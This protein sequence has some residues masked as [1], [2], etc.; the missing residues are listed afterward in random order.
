MLMSLFSIILTNVTMNIIC[1]SVSAMTDNE[2]G[3]HSR[4]FLSTDPYGNP[5]CKQCS[6]CPP[7]TGVRRLCEGTSDTECEICPVGMYSGTWSSTRV[8]Q[9]CQVC[10]PHRQITRN[11]TSQHNSKC[12][13]SCDF[14]FYLNALTDFCDECS[15]CFPDQP[16]H[17]PPRITECIQQGVAREFQCMPTMGNNRHYSLLRSGGAGADADEASTS[18]DQQGVENE[19][20]VGNISDGKANTTITTE[21]DT[22]TDL[23]ATFSQQVEVDKLSDCT[24]S[25]QVDIFMTQQRTLGVH[26]HTMSDQYGTEDQKT[27]KLRLILVLVIVCI[28]IG[29]LIFTLLLY[30]KRRI[31]PK[32]RQE[33]QEQARFVKNEES[34]DTMTIISRDWVSPTSYPNDENSVLVPRDAEDDAESMN[35]SSSED[36]ETSIEQKHNENIDIIRSVPI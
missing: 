20:T 9:P 36:T 24:S 34:D 6:K 29:L 3:G 27:G 8:C 7:G 2:C 15:W 32:Q 4:K 16:E 13:D 5:I 19:A 23:T 14:G 35:D 1:V 22:V 18:K 31:R 17:S 21:N 30:Y 26:V 12:S 33:L 10:S 28:S 11:C 25:K